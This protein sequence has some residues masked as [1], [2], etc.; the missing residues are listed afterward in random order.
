MNNEISLQAAVEKM[1]NINQSNSLKRTYVRVAERN[2]VEYRVE[3]NYVLRSY[4]NVY[5]KSWAR[6]VS[7]MV[8]PDGDFLNLAQAKRLLKKVTA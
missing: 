8:T 7:I 2:T 5:S 3:G 6:R 4:V 1:A